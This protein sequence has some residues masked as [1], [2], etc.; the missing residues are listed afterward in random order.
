MKY[1]QPDGTHVF[2]LS[3][4]Q[5]TNISALYERMFEEINSNYTYKIRCIKRPWF[6]N[7]CILP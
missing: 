2:D 3:D 5:V 6:P 1:F 4:E 7:F